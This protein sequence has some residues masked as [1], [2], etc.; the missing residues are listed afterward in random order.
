MDK[1]SA[2]GL[3]PRQFERVKLHVTV[4]N[5][6]FRK[7]PSGTAQAEVMESRRNVKERESFDAAGVLRVR[8]SLPAINT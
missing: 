8:Y 2:A 7:D 1:F 6:L 5:T 3:M 4:M